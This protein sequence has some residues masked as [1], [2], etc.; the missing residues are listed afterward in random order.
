MHAILLL[1][2]PLSNVGIQNFDMWGMYN[3]AKAYRCIKNLLPIAESRTGNPAMVTLKIQ[4][5]C[6]M[7]HDTTLWVNIFVHSHLGCGTNPVSIRFFRR[8]HKYL[9]D[10]K[11]VANKQ[12]FE[13]KL[14]LTQGSH[15]F[16]RTK[17]KTFSRPYL[18]FSRPVSIISYKQY[19][20]T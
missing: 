2:W 19:V 9:K 8:S 12:D 3:L 20:T 6:S 4:L 16:R 14:N 15:T 10:A 1:F 18:W 13:I 17:F 5:D 7:V 11:R